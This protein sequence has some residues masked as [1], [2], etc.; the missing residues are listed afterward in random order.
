MVPLQER[1]MGKVRYASSTAVSGI[2]TLRGRALDYKHFVGR[3]T[4]R[5]EYLATL[6]DTLKTQDI[7]VEFTTLEGD[8][9]AYL[10]RK[11]FDP[12]IQRDIWDMLVIRDGE[13]KTKIARKDKV[14]RRYIES[15][16]D[17]AGREASHPGTAGGATESASTP[18]DVT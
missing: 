16:V 17:R 1:R 3:D 8:A 11:Y 7:R 4:P 14:G 15:S 12:D 13:L 10:I 2:A 6:P 5:N 18:R 9:K